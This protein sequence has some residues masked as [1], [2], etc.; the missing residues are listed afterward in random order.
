MLGLIIPPDL[1][2]EAVTK[3]SD[4]SEDTRE[5]QIN[6]QVGMGNNYERLE[7]LGD[8]FLKMATTIAL[9][10]QCPDK[11]EFAYHVER[12]LLICNKNLFNTAVDKGLQE[13]VRSKSFSRRTW[14]PPGLKLQKGKAPQEVAGH[15][16]SDKSIADVCEALIG[17]AYLS[18]SSVEADDDFTKQPDFDM[19][20]KAVSAVVRNKNHKMQGW[21]DYYAVYKK[22]GWQVASPTAT[23]REG[24]R[25]VED[26][27]RYKFKWPALLRSAF[28]HPSYPYE[29]VPDYQCLEFLG[30]ALLDMVCVDFLFKKFPHADP[31]WLTEHKMAM[32][33]NQFLGSLCVKLGLHRH[34]LSVHSELIKSIEAYVFQLQEA[35][36]VS[37]EDKGKTP[38]ERSNCSI[39][40]NV[41]SPPKCLADMVEA[42]IGAVFVDSEYDYNTVRRFFEENIRPYFEDMSLY[43]S[44]AN[45]HPITVLSTK[46][47]KDFSCNEWRVLVKEGVPDP[48]VAGA[49]CFTQT[50]VAAGVLIHGKVFAVA[51]AASGRYAKIAVA[52]DALAKLEGM[53]AGDFRERIGCECGKDGNVKPPEEHGTAI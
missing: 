43:D 20:I 47:A 5:E 46:L 27:L 13:Y 7:F 38:M 3:D 24:A 14:Y 35:E 28:K 37:R 6:F 22:P 42:Y 18:C 40:M 29:K 10:S 11:N 51:R 30:D 36:A 45:R 50:E 32:V 26:T 44:F 52:K 21:E 48:E 19:A 4:N 49:A 31:Q 16:L 17:A 2:L 25:L 8:S 53:S 34:L 15:S 23:M 12:M 9:F 39:W 33:S 41:S 1:A